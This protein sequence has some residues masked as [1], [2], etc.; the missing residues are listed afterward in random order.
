MGQNLSEVESVFLDEVFEK[1]K[2]F[3]NFK[4]ATKGRRLGKHNMKFPSDFMSRSEKMKHRKAGEV[5]TTNM[6]N[7]ILPITEFDALETHEKRNRLQYWRTEKSNKEILAGMGISNKKYYDIVAELALPKAPRTNNSVKV[8][9]AY[10][11]K[12][13]PKVETP[14]AVQ[15]T[16]P[17]Q[18]PTTPVQEIL[19]EGLNLV[20]HGTYTAEQIQKQLTKFSLI[21]EDDSEEYYFEFR[22]MQKQPKQK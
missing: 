6:Y 11:K 20:F 5:L 8:R 19:V 13:E 1:K 10:T 21:L 7:D 2:E 15:E 14:V 18:V 4:N 16:V 3:K 12:Q 9:K 17:E 22:L